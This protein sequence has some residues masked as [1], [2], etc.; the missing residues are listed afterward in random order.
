M[1]KNKGKEEYNFYTRERTCA[2]KGLS[3]YIDMLLNPP[4]LVENFSKHSAKNLWCSL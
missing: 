4:L 1:Y 3:S 2:G